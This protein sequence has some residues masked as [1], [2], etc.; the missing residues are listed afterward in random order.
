MTEA[1]KDYLEK[2]NALLDTGDYQKCR[3][4]YAHQLKPGMVGCAHP[5]P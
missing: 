3:V 1:P 2:G 5:T 4:G